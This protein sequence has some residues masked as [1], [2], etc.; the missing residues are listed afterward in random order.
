MVI[1]TAPEVSKLVTLFVLFVYNAQVHISHITT[2]ITCK[3]FQHVQA[4]LVP[5]SG[6]H[7]LA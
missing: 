5:T 6:A 1:S 2:C 3:Y 7:K 4:T